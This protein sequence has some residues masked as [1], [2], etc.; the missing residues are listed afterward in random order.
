M[1]RMFKGRLS[2]VICYQVYTYTETTKYTSIRR[3]LTFGGETQVVSCSDGL[4][5]LA[6][7]VH[8]DFVSAP[9]RVRTHT[10]RETTGYEPRGNRLRA[11][12]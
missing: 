3:L 2:R 10:R 8:K 1:Q 7:R 12:R 5:L 6:G 4:C 11:D 9:L